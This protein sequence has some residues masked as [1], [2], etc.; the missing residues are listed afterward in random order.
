[1][2]KLF[3]ISLTNAA[4]IIIAV[5]DYEVKV[6]GSQLLLIESFFCGISMQVNA[7]VLQI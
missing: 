5:Y 3:N 7:I 2:D 6:L 4:N 1:M